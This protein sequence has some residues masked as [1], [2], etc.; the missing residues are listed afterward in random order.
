MVKR[1]QSCYNGQEQTETLATASNS[2]HSK[3]RPM[4]HLEGQ[5]KIPRAWKRILEPTGGEG[6][7]EGR[8]GGSH[9]EAESNMDPKGRRQ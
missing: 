2:L 6:R 7:T 9:Q 3:D 4:A 5:Q 8:R 1:N